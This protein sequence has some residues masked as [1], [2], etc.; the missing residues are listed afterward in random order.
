MSR[1]FHRTGIALCLAA[2]I[3]LV[4]SGMALAQ[5]SEKQAPDLRGG[6]KVEHRIELKGLP[7]LVLPAMDPAKGRVYFA[8]RACVVCHKVNGIGGSRAAALDLDVRPKTID[9]LGFSARM[10]RHGGPMIALQ[11]RLFGEPIDLTAEELGAIIAF[12]HDPVEQDK[13]TVTDIPTVVRKFMENEHKG[14]K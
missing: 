7:D 10:L 6:G 8:S 4:F 5:S 12:L 11:Q 3:A 9:I 2:S 13:F 1:T 14:P